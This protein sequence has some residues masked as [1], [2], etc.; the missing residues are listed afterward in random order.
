MTLDSTGGIDAGDAA[1]TGTASDATDAAANSDAIIYD[2]T[3]ADRPDDTDLSFGVEEESGDLG[4]DTQADVAQPSISAQ[5]H[6]QTYGWQSSQ[7]GKAGTVVSVGTTGQSKRLE[8]VKIN[9]SGVS[10]SIQYKTHVQTYGW[11]DWKTNGA[12]SGTTGQA[13]R[14]EAIQIKLTG[15]AANNFDVFY[16]VHAQTY[17]WLGW[18]KNGASAGTQGFSKRLEKLE[19]VVLPKGQTPSGYS[20]D[21][22]AFK[23]VQLS[24]SAH[25]QTYGT[26][27]GSVDSPTATLTLG[28]T[29]QSKRIEAFSL[30]MPGID[31]GIKYQAHVQTY[32]WTGEKSNGQLAGTTGQSKRLEAVKIS[33]TGNAANKYD[34]YYRVHVQ[35]FGWLDWAKNG[36][37]AGSAGAAKRAE[38]IQVKLVAKGGAAPGATSVAY[39]DNNN[40]GIT[41][42]CMSGTG[43]STNYASVGMGATA[44]STGQSKALTGIALKVSS[45]KVSGGISYAAHVAQKGWLS[46]VSDGAQ[47]QS[48]SNNV[49]AIKMSLTGNLSKYY[50]IYYRAHVAGYGWMGWAKNGA[51]AGT[52]GLSKNMEAYQVKIV[53]KGAAAPGSTAKSF[54]DKN[55]FLGGP[56]TDAEL[57]NI[58]RTIINSKTGTGS[59]ALRNAFNYVASLKYKKGSVYPSGSWQSWS[60]PFAKEMYYNGR[61]NCYRFASLFCWIARGL[62]YDAKTIAGQCPETGGG[63]TAHGWVE[64]TI[65]GTAYICDPDMANAYPSR[66]WYMVTYANAPINYYK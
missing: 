34:V 23:Q 36:E 13:K 4:I 48:G 24:Y 8:A 16:R 51:Y 38:A 22:E 39:L 64:I 45:S 15:D 33:L 42:Q 60:V 29:G 6:V 12:L 2:D 59:N 3:A 44:G 43:G 53:L 28:T 26:R 52:T 30:S 54:S 50:D 66:N 20:A 37:A 27:T 58:V 63:R 56:S 57:N 25:I 40:L 7:V 49:Q 21:T 62:G 41:M 65:N 17:G 32:G 11:Q 55:G 19:V 10:G 61:G 1:A 31:G 18:A 47:S 46:N 14:L 5:A 35:T 9:L